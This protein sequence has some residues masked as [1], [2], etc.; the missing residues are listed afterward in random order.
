M[1]KGTSALKRGIMRRRKVKT[2]FITMENPPMWNCC[3][4]LYTERI[5]SV[6][7]V[8]TSV[9]QNLQ[10]KLTGKQN[11]PKF[12]VQ[13]YKTNMLIREWFLTS[14]IKAAIHLDARHT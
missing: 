6:F 11:L 3:I 2:P 9:F 5:T 10:N 4:G 14:S 12:A 13:A 8:F 7:T 1:F